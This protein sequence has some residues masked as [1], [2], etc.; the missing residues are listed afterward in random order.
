M[1]CGDCMYR[2]HLGDTSCHSQRSGKSW[3]KEAGSSGLTEGS[4]GTVA[5]VA[6]D[7][8]FVRVSRSTVAFAKGVSRTGPR[9]I[10][11]SYALANRL[12]M[13]R[14]FGRTVSRR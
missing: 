14:P 1:P 11:I 6:A 8:D 12:W 5:G 7:E 10:A 4:A 13:I 9:A 2:P 3:S